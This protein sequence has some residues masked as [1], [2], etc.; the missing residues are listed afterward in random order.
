MDKIVSKSRTCCRHQ[1]YEYSNT[2]EV[3]DAHYFNDSVATIA[4]SFGTEH[5]INTSQSRPTKPT[6]NIKA[7]TE[8]DVMRLIG[9]LKSSRAKDVIAMNTLMLKE[10][11]TAL[12]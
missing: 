2:A 8:S 3:A 5:R 12:V 11:S 6:F 1:A 9:S 4:M 10:F 7:V